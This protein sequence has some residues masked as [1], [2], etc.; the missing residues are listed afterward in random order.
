MLYSKID[1][2]RGQGDIIML[3]DISVKTQKN[4][5]SNADISDW[6][7]KKK[8]KKVLKIS[9]SENPN[10]IV[11]SLASNLY[12]QGS[13]PGFPSI[14]NFV[15]NVEISVSEMSSHIYSVIILQAWFEMWFQSPSKTR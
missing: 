8:E 11:K 9:I 2:I 13:N 14:T 3:Y 4:N 12:Y 1:C 7:G 6:C 5:V 10:K 15:Q